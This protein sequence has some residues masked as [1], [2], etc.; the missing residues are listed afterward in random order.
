MEKEYEISDQL[1]EMVEKAVDT[2]FEGL[3]NSKPI[4]PWI[5]THPKD[6]EQYSMT[7]LT[8][9]ELKQALQEAR[10]KVK[11]AAN[12][13]DA[14]LIGFDG[15][16]STVD[17]RVNGLFCEIGEPG[18]QTGFEYMVGYK[19]LEDK[20]IELESEYDGVLKEHNNLL[21]N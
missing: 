11:D 7:V 15:S 16:I 17:G 1:G 21:G 5:L 3:Q 6:S 14:N 9:M 18:N 19:T 4:E 10:K 13:I 20:T 2:D 8:G 12:D